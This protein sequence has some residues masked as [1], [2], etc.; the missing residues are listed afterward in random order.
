M[1]LSVRFIVTMS[2]KVS[3][4]QLMTVVLWMLPRMVQ[5]PSVG[6]QWVP[7][8]H[9]LAMMDL[10]CR[11]SRR[12]HAKMMVNGLEVHQ[13]VS[14]SQMLQTSAFMQFLQLDSGE[15]HAD[16]HS[17]AG[18]VRDKSADVVQMK[19]RSLPCSK[20][21]IYDSNYWLSVPTY[22]SYFIF[23]YTVAVD[24]G[25]LANPANG[26]VDLTGTTFGSIAT[27]TCNSGFI[28]ANGN[29]IRQCGANEQWSGTAPNCV[30]KLLHNYNPTVPKVLMQ[31]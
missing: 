10:D 17:I 5:C 3:P 22:C 2:G 1:Q 31:L 9:I 25:N 12:G 26:R 23:S 28:L 19:K 15:V 14:V 11:D 18:T 21:F 7:L 16:W 20:P 30:R 6:Q 13:L 27:Y 8:L 4:L 29:R 24:C